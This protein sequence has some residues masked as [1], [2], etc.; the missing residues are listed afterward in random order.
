MARAA[1]LFSHSSAGL[2]ASAPMIRELAKTKALWRAHKVSRS[3]LI[4]S[5]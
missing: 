5:V 3:E 1:H 4:R 2:M